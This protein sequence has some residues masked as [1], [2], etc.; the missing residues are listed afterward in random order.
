MPRGQYVATRLVALSAVVFC[1]SVAGHTAASGMVPS[2][3]GLCLALILSTGLSVASLAKP[4]SWAW[5]LLFIAGAQ[6][7]IHVVLVISGSGHR[8]PMGGVVPLL[9][10]AQMVVAHASV[11]IVVAGTLA[12]GERVLLAW[13]RLL[14]AALGPRFVALAPVAGSTPP[15]LDRDRWSPSIR[16]V[17]SGVARRGPPQLRSV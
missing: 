2:L 14:A 8:P 13:A 12:T 4:R 16:L 15:V 9:P 11:T 3:T 6:A 7:L 1:L 17:V 5:L 10:S